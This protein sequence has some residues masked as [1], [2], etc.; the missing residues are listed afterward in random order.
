MTDVLDELREAFARYSWGHYDPFSVIDAFAAEHPGLVD[1]TIRCC[2]C[3]AATR[4]R[5]R[6]VDALSRESFL[7]GWHANFGTSLY[8]WWEGLYLCPTCA[9][10][11]G[12]SD[13]TD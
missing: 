5:T 2:N 1:L 11:A 4:E 9:K 12:V 8:D 7:E 6:L 13:A 3:G 10:E